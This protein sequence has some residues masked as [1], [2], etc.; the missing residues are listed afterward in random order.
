MQVSVHVYKNNQRLFEARW[1]H[2]WSGWF[3][4]FFFLFVFLEMQ[5]E[6]SGGGIKERRNGSVSINGTLT[7]PVFDNLLISAVVFSFHLNPSGFRALDM[8]GLT[9][10]ERSSEIQK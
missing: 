2:S 1:V 4:C 6:I 7:I 5:T 3:G 10:H 9:R 8:R